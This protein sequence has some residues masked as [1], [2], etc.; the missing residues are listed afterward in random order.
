[1]V[2]SNEVKQIPETIWLDP[3]LVKK[4]LFVI[5]VSKTYFPNN[6]FI[7]DLQ[8]W[9][10]EGLRRYNDNAKPWT[11]DQTD[12]LKNM[13]V[14]LAR[15]RS[16][17]AFKAWI[18]RLLYLI[19]TLDRKQSR[20]ISIHFCPFCG[21]NLEVN[22]FSIKSALNYCGCGALFFVNSGRDGS[23]PGFPD[24][25]SSLHGSHEWM[26][27]KD[28]FYNDDYF[29]L[30]PKS[31]P[32]TFN[33]VR[34]ICP[35]CKED[36]K[37]C[38][39][40][41]VESGC[42]AVGIVHFHAR[43]LSHDFFVRHLS[44]SERNLLYKDSLIYGIFPELNGTIV[45]SKNIQKISMPINIK[46]YEL[47]KLC[48]D[49]WR[50]VFAKVRP[51]AKTNDLGIL[52]PPNSDV[53]QVI[54]KLPP[55][56]FSGTTDSISGIV[57]RLEFAMKS[58]RVSIK[59][60][61]MENVKIGPSI[62]RI[63]VYLDESEKF[64]DLLNRKNDIERIV[65]TIGPI[66]ISHVRGTNYISIDFQRS[67][68]DEVLFGQLLTSKEW[69]KP[70]ND[71]ELR[72][73]AGL[74]VDG[75]IICGDMTSFPHLLVAGITRT[76]KS[77]FLES[78]I[79]SMVSRYSPDQVRFII[80]DPKGYEFPLFNDFPHISQIYRDLDET[81]NCL[82]GIIH[83]LFEAR[84][85]L[86]MKYHARSLKDFH[87]KCSNFE[88]IITPY[89]VVVIDEVAALFTTM[90]K[91][92]SPKETLL[93]LASLGAAFGVHLVVATQRPSAKIIDGDI[94][95]NFSQRVCLRL[96]SGVDSRVVIDDL[97]AESLSKG[98][99]LLYGEVNALT[100]IQGFKC[101]TEN[102][103]KYAITVERCSICCLGVSKGDELVNISRSGKN[104]K[105]CRICS[106]G[107]KTKD[108]E[109]VD[110]LFSRGANFYG[111]KNFDKNIK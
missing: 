44:V 104:L 49:N 34:N 26:L 17:L 39:D 52:P 99:D 77:V 1:M 53:Q 43:K 35:F 67:K 108:S 23:G 96:S 32:P 55:L 95:A 73:G 54:S 16:S 63:L 80:V 91:K 19:G 65:G 47:N 69:Q 68:K 103:M 11:I 56:D 71:G 86:F 92:P 24:L 27:V 102:L 70:D 83:V 89:I 31:L 61:N 38:Q 58:I 76:G 25:V 100:R 101:K 41:F 46:K 33:A 85:N 98:G 42:G 87:Q 20:K 22:V 82:N 2:E 106:E 110:L 3:L 50:T 97:G 72:F 93:H 28:R 9:C 30:K 29:S 48:A 62:I 6:K 57:D 75:E 14:V 78:V 36:L 90:K 109:Y 74:S 13:L 51:G 40:G 66:L 107:F 37:V 7:N 18:E 105:I 88:K 64:S 79:T 12:C 94:K 45:S 21:G 111:L 59:P 81:L 8:V 60:I 15:S 5:D 10:N 4:Q 84:K